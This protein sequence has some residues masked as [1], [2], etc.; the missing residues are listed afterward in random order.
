[1]RMLDLHRLRTL[2]YVSESVLEFLYECSASMV[3]YFCMFV[4]STL[5]IVMLD[6]PL[7]IS[8]LSGSL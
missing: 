2:R 4:C 1:M 7:L 5:Y 3:L 6:K 8:V